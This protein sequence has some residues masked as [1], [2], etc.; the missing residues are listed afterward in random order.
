MPEPE[1]DPFYI[2]PT[3]ILSIVSDLR[4]SANSVDQRLS[5]YLEDLSRGT[6]RDAIAV[7]GMAARD[8]NVIRVMTTDSVPE[9]RDHLAALIGPLNWATSFIRQIIAELREIICGSK[10]KP[11]GLGEKSQ[12][13]IAAITVA[14]ASRFHIPPGTATGLAV[15]VLLALSRATKKAFCKM[16]DEEVLAALKTNS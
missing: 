11:K 1:Y 10:K 3:T 2:E 5:R 12:A 14:I 8:A 15:L 13:I 6:G 7:L 4:E 9:R 16:T